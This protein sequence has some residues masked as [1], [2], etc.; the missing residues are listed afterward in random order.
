MIKL[1]KKIQVRQDIV[2]GLTHTDLK[3]VKFQIEAPSKSGQA[4]YD[5]LIT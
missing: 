1:R 5:M 2:T 3:P 4:Y